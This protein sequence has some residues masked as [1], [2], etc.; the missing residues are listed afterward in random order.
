[1][2]PQINLASQGESIGE[3]ADLDR[4]FHRVSA[5]ALQTH[6]PPVMNKKTASSF[7]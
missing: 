2:E 5:K 1:M 4:L 7:D 3:V 6:E